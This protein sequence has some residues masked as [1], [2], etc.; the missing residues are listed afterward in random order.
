MGNLVW[1]TYL[2][3]LEHSAP[4]RNQ[5]LWVDDQP[6]NNTYERQAFE[7]LGLHFTLASSTA[8]AFEKLAYGR[9]VA[10]I[11]DMDRPEGPRAGYTL[12]DRLR[13]EG[14]QT[15]LFFYT[16]SN[17]PEHRQQALEH[18]GQGST[19]DPQ[20]LIEMVTRAVIKDQ[21]V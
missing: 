8:D 3:L 14:N 18:G 7:A 20:E 1:D 2:S 4:W 16:S 6:K 19:N 12:L 15:P 11:S 17:A 5:I 21:S 9:Y 13:Q 10:I